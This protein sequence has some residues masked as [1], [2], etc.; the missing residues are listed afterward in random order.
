MAEAKEIIQDRAT[1]VA[2]E[3]LSEIVSAE[4]KAKI[5]LS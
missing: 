5:L 4:D 3:A 2:Y 1:E